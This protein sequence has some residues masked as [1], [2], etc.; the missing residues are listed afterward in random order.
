MTTRDL[1]GKVAL[2]TGSATGIGRAIAETLAARGAAVVAHGLDRAQNDAALESWRAAGW[3]AIASDADL[4]TADGPAALL[5]TVRATLGPPDILILNASVEMP[6]VLAD[7]TAQAMTTQTAVNVTASALLLQAC[8]PDMARRGW[9]RVVAIGSV[10]EE[11]PNARHLFYAATKAALTSMVLNLARNER[12]SDVTF[13]VVRPGA[14]ATDRNR[15]VL[16]DAGFARSVVDR[17]PLSRLGTPQDCAGAVSLL[18]SQAGAYI[19]G[20]IVAVDGGL[21][22]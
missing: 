9:G 14:I 21:R 11:R 2:V 1:D 5:E 15:A 3:R 19:N 7:L 10:Q 6:Q 8:L 18:C 13:N 22:L 4:A 12:L 16:S 17:I 20:A